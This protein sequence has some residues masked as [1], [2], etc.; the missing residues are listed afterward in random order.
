MLREWEQPG[1]RGC[2][3][4]SG[5]PGAMRGRPG[6]VPPR[7]P[8]MSKL[9]IWRP[10]CPSTLVHWKPPVKTA[11]RQQFFWGEWAASP[12]QFCRHDSNFLGFRVLIYIGT[13]LGDCRLAPI[14]GCGRQPLQPSR[15]CQGLAG[16]RQRPPTHS[17]RGVVGGFWILGFG[18]RGL[19]LRV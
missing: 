11:S 16:A 4:V 12:H 15:A 19:G 14:Q 2:P 8:G 17:R 9:S 3:G 6:S 18:F 13:E 5:V 10:P 1:V 7:R